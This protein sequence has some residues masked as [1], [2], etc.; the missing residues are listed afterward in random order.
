MIA[1]GNFNPIYQSGAAWVAT[2]APS[3]TWSS[4]ASYVD[5]T[6]LAA[7]IFG[8]GIYTSTNGGASW[9][10][11]AAPP[12]SWLTIASSKDENKLAAAAIGE[13]IYHS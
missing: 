7:T 12:N 1:G 3:S 2:S 9:A 6:K 8:D 13:C 5:G 10:P 4:I 11:T